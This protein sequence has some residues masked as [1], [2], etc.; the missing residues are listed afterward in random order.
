[1]RPYDALV[2]DLDGTLVGA[3]DEVHPRTRAAIARIAAEGVRVMV[4]TG[5]SEVGALPILDGLGLEM[6]SVVFNGAGVWCPRRRKLVEGR[7]LSDRAVKRVL[8]WAEAEQILVVVMRNGEKFGSPPRNELEAAGVSGMIGLVTVPFDAL[9]REYVIRISLFSDRHGDSAS[10][11][12]EVERAVDLPLYLT[13]FPLDHL[14]SHVGNPLQVVDVQPPCRGKSEA[15]RI[16]REEYG[17]HPERVVAVGDGGNDVPMLLDAG[18]GCAMEVALP[19]A[20]AAAQRILGP[21]ESDT[22]ACLIDELF[23]PR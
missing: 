7:L 2:L 17:I 21:C 11:A 6:P 5:R 13:D 15:L 8:A 14:A 12:R 18:L 20:H 9:P 16:L 3:S 4:A 10:F 19:E 1:M 23:P 22:I